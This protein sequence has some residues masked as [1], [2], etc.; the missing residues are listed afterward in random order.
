MPTPASDPACPGCAALRAEMADMQQQLV[1]LQDTV[2]RLQK[3]SSN[4]SKPPS[5]DIVK[6]PK[7]AAKG[8]K[9]RR[10]GGPPV[11]M[12]YE[13]TFQLADADVVH[14]HH[15]DRCPDCTGD[16]L[17]HLAGGEQTRYQYELVEKPVM[18]HAHQSHV[19][20]CATCDRMPAA[21]FPAAV[22]Q[23]GLVGPRLTG[24]IGY[25][26]GSGHLSYTTLQALLDEGFST[27]LSTGMLAKVVDKVS[28]ALQPIYQPLLEALP[29]QAR[30]NIDETGHKDRGQLLWTWV[31]GTP[32][33]TVFHIAASRGSQV[34]EQILGNECAAVLG[35]DYFSAYRAFMKKAPVTVQFCLAHLIRE[36]RFLT[37]S[38]NRAIAQYG[39]RLLAQLKGLF[40]LIHRQHQ[41]RPETFQRRLEQAR[42]H[43]LK[44]GRRTKAGGAAA[45]LAKRF[46]THGRDYFTFITCPDIEPTN[47]TSERALRFC[48]IDR[49]IT[50]GTRGRKGQQWC[51]HFWTIRET[52]RQQGLGVCRFI[53]QA[54]HA[55][56]QGATPPALLPT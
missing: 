3:N 4:S 56:F 5:S 9:K 34:L 36:V 39:Q 43:C 19:Y 18:L 33:F 48:V 49:R 42:A 27:S 16:S 20:W 53:Q 55:S 6:P 37:E 23:G 17:V 35:H 7:P 50:Q 40:R 14:D 15:L 25:L 45:V 24:L 46:R 13:R 32:S 22:S 21:P 41:L 51:E 11:H 38:T 1:A 2:A 47:N 8:G 12:K 30:I 10:Q 28:Q 54:V 52:C 29:H 44:T 26:K 31:F